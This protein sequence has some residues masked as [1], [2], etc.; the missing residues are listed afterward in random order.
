MKGMNDQPSLYDDICETER[1]IDCYGTNLVEFQFATCSSSQGDSVQND[2]SSATE[3][4]TSLCSVSEGEDLSQMPMSQLY[5][6]ICHVEAVIQNC[7]TSVASREIIS[8]LVDRKMAS[9]KESEQEDGEK[10]HEGSQI[11]SKSFDS[12]VRE[13]QQQ[14]TEKDVQVFSDNM[15]APMCCSQKETGIQRQ[16]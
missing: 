4:S 15:A 6:E 7:L 3:S 1:A 13:E 8:V 5:Q 12:H 16:V 14:N 11:N 2:Y 10:I 9:V